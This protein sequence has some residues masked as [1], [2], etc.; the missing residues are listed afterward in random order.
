[1]RFILCYTAMLLILSGCSEEFFNQ[2]AEI[3]PP[4][5]KRQLVL[6]QLVSDADSFL[7]VELTRNFGILETVKESNWYV[8]GAEIEWWVD[9][10][11]I[12]TLEPYPFIRRR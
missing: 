1:M 4:F 12:R 3:D 9:G 5:Y 2:T 7:R 10:Q 6:H 11:K 8:L